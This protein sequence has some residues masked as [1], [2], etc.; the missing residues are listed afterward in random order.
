MITGL[1]DAPSLQPLFESQAGLGALAPSPGGALV[2][3]LRDGRVWVNRVAD[4]SVREL[5]LPGRAMT[6]GAK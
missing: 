3:F 6:A 2:A 1:P 4:R 5:E